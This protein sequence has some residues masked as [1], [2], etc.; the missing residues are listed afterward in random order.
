MFTTNPLNVFAIF[1]F[2][3]KQQKQAEQMRKAQT[4]KMTRERLKQEAERKR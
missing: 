3:E 1:F 4:E 2:Q